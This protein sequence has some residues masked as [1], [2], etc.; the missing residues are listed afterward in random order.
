[1][2]EASRYCP[3]ERYIAPGKMPLRKGVSF[4]KT[5]PK[6]SGRRLAVPCALV[7]ATSHIRPHCRRM[8]HLT[9]LAFGILLGCILMNPIVLCKKIITT[10]VNPMSNPS[11]SQMNRQE[12][13]QMNTMVS[14]TST[15]HG[16]HFQYTFFPIE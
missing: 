3:L 15:T 16:T 11:L 13:T 1:M 12:L 14:H 9:L 10:S 7:I 6:E 4:A 5:Q 8:S 2:R